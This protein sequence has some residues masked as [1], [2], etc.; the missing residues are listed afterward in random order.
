LSDRRDPRFF[1]LLAQAEN[2]LGQRVKEH[3]ALAD[4][5]LSVGQFPH[6]AEQL[7]LA[8]RTKG[9]SNYQRQKLLFRLDEVE[10]IILDLEE[11]RR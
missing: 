11:P 2:L 1:N 3:S 5:Y 10:Q 4:Y 7:R 9:L 8:R 6:A